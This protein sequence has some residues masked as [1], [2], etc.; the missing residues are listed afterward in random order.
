MS[1]SLSP[2][3]SPQISPV[4]LA[5]DDLPVPAAD[6]EAVDGDVLGLESFLFE[7]FLASDQ[8][9]PSPDPSSC[10]NL[11]L[12]SCKSVKLQF[13][14]SVVSLRDLPGQPANMDSLRLPLPRPSFP[15]AAWR[16]ALQGYF[17]AEELIAAF[18]FGWDFSFLSPPCPKDAT[19][20]LGSSNIAPQD[21]D[22]YISTE[23]RH[24]ALIGPFYEGELPFPVFHSLLGSV[25]KI[26]VRRTITDC[27]QM[28]A[29]IN[30]FISAHVHRGKTWKL[31]EFHSAKRI[32]ATYPP[33]ELS[34][35]RLEGCCQRYALRGHGGLDYWT[36]LG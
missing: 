11:P 27:S 8:A 7:R 14:E 28:G 5:V 25:P 34:A 30:G 6:P 13:I 15:V 18:T 21:I 31:H 3:P 36:V 10:H 23:L 17:D 16:F 2:S 22:T 26:P 29:G 9:A 33:V 12:G 19:R 32:E 35:S 24:A 4:P 1:S 20:N